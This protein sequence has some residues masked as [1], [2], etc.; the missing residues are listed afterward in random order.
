MATAT[1]STSMS[2]MSFQ[3]TGCGDRRDIT[4]KV[5]HKIDC[6]DGLIHQGTSTIEVPG[7]TPGSAVIVFL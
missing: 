5:K 3:S 6:M 1:S 2:L 4:K 7:A